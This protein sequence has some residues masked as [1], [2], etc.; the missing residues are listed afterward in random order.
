MA[1]CLNKKPEEPTERPHG[2]RQFSD[3]CVTA[4]S[5]LRQ[6][7]A[8]NY[9]C[10]WETSVEAQRWWMVA[11]GHEVELQDIVKAAGDHAAMKMEDAAVM[12]KDAAMECWDAAMSTGDAAVTRRGSADAAKYPSPENCGEADI[13]ILLGEFG[14]NLLNWL[15]TKTSECL[16]DIARG[17]K[18][19]CVVKDGPGILDADSPTPSQTSGRS[20]A[21]SGIRRQ[22]IRCLERLRAATVSDGFT[23]TVKRQPSRPVV[24]LVLPFDGTVYAVPYTVIPVKFTAA[25][26]N[27]KFRFAE[28]VLGIAQ[29]S[30]LEQNRQ[31]KDTIHSPKSR[32][33]KMEQQPVPPQFKVSAPPNH[34]QSSKSRGRRAS[35]NRQPPSVLRNYRKHE[36]AKVARND[37]LVSWTRE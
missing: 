25:Y 4:A 24:P 8:A 36:P 23:V 32:N 29:C 6:P 22:W 27:L 1:P 16:K 3:R 17:K 33:K 7:D 9:F 35:S 20:C 15:N 28:F 11:M 34:T 31:K 10:P 13:P 19:A 21:F 30:V 37:H 14:V 2:G 12:R 5:P 26:G 18:E